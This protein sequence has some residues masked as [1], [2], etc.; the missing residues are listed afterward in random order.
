MITA[1]KVYKIIFALLI[2]AA[3]GI[4]ILLM[5][6]CTIQRTG[7]VDSDGSSY[8]QTLV[9]PPLGK[10]DEAA[11]SMSYDLTED[12]TWRLAIGQNSQGVDN[13]G[14]ESAIIGVVNMLVKNELLSAKN[15]NLKDVIGTL[16]ERIKELTVET[17]T[18]F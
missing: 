15:D 14:M 9:V 10:L 8:N 4:V 3:F 16:E 18:T 7:F 2:L 12:G 11:G 13:T 6:S 17:E 1:S 5:L